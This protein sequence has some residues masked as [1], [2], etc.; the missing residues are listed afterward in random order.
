MADHAKIL[1]TISYANPSADGLS[2]VELTFRSP[3]ALSEVEGLY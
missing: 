2:A 3:F 1:A